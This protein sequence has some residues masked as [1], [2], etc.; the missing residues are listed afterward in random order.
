MAVV[1]PLVLGEAPGGGVAGED[2]AECRHPA[3]QLVEGVDD[4]RLEC[5]R[6]L[7]TSVLERAVVR[8]NEVD[9]V[10]LE[11]ARESGDRPGALVDE[12]AGQHDVPDQPSLVGIG[13][14]VA[15][16]GQLAYLSEIVQEA[17]G[18]D[19]V[20][21]ELRIVIADAPGELEHRERVLAEPARPGVMDGLRGRRQPEGG[22][23]L[24][25]VEES[26]QQVADVPV[27]NLGAERS[28]LREQI[29]GV[30]SRL[31][32]IPLAE[33]DGMSIHACVL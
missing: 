16:A 22:A 24:G 7:G 20:A 14:P 13:E 5:L 8:G 33:G 3:V 1:E 11:L 31:R 26:E 27:A 9:E 19:E 25:V 15:V 17:S 29:V 32:D 12:L 30:E 28:H 4:E 6:L 10:H 2:R 21:I 18:G 23:Q